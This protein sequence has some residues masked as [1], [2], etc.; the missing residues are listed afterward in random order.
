LSIDRARRTAEVVGVEIHLTPTEFRLLCHLAEHPDRLVG[1]QEL[2]RAVWGYGYDDDIHLLQVTMRGL[3][4]RIAQVT[5]QTLIETAYGA[6][7]RMDRA[8]QRRVDTADRHRA[9]AT[10]HP[11]GSTKADDDGTD[12]GPAGSVRAAR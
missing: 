7:Y 8:G 6:G 1:H 11:Y 10:L 9:R 2:L 5:D 4:G 3:R 12:Q